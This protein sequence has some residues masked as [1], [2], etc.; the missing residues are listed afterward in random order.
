MMDIVVAELL[1]QS[2]FEKPLRGESFMGGKDTPWEIDNRTLY[3]DGHFFDLGRLNDAFLASVSTGEPMEGD[4]R[5]CDMVEAADSISSALDDAGHLMRELRSGWGGLANVSR[6]FSA[7]WGSFVGPAVRLG[8]LIRA[9]S[10]CLRTAIRLRDHPHERARRGALPTAPEHRLVARLWRRSGI[11]WEA[12][13]SLGGWN[14]HPAPA[15]PSSRPRPSSSIRPRPSS[16]PE[17][18]PLTD[19]EAEMST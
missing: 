4:S 5:A 1:C 15:R 14:V 16:R 3:A 2:L 18:W 11:T 12:I 13:C 9:Q 10:M 19:E 7:A 8:P 6:G 17:P